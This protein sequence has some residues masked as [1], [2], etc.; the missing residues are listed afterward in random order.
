MPTPTPK[1][2]VGK[3]YAFFLGRVCHALATGNADTI[4]SLLPYYQYNNGLRYGIPGSGEGQTADPTI[5]RTW[6]ASAR[7]HCVSYTPGILGHG[8]VLTAG[9]KKPASSSLIELDMFNQ[10]WK[11]ND[12]TF[13]NRAYLEQ[14]I[15]S[16]GP[17][18]RYHR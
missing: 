3:P 18:V 7:P 10:I 2:I 17:V 1:P 4:I 9:W 8:A 6:L 14:A 12:F 5:M 11:I 15:H 13:G 16:S